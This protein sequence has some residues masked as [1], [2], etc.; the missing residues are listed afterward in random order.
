MNDLPVGFRSPA[1]LILLFLGMAVGR[2]ESEISKLPSFNCSLLSNS[3][4]SFIAL[5]AHC[6]LC[7]SLLARLETMQSGQGGRAC[8]LGGVRHFKGEGF[9]VGRDRM[10]HMQW[11]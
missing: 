8:K 1:L 3:L 10:K 4:G 2:D 9:F 6:F 5:I 11:L 7:S